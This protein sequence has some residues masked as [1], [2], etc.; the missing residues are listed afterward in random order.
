MDAQGIPPTFPFHVAKA[1]APQAQRPAK[2]PSIDKQEITKPRTQSVNT[3]VAGKVSTA[4]NFA[5]PPAPKNSDS[6]PL[7]RH[8]ADKNAAATGV[9]LGRSVDVNG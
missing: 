4:P 7:Y 8:P 3:L 6:L 5:A 2:T 9:S 1:Y